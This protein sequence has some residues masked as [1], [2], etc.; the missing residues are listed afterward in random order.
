MSDTQAQSLVRDFNEI[1]KM[2]YD[3]HRYGENNA[4]DCMRGPRRAAINAVETVDAIVKTYTGEFVHIYGLRAQLQNAVKHTGPNPE[5][6]EG[7]LS[8]DRVQ[9]V[10]LVAFGQEIDGYVP[11]VSDAI[12]EEVG[13]AIGTTGDRVY[14]EIGCFTRDANTA[15][16]ARTVIAKTKTL[17]SSGVKAAWETARAEAAAAWVT[18]NEK[19]ELVK[20]AVLL[21]GRLEVRDELEEFMK[22]RRV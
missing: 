21:K 15:L 1:E 7:E 13:T 22:R 9:Q 14:E 12:R 10:A 2:S 18:V 4:T 8:H 5:L 20:K 11:N 16:A 17:V 19:D 3:E 6:E